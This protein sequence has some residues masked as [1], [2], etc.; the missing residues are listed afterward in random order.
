MAKRLL[1]TFLFLVFFQDAWAADI[2]RQKKE[3]GKQWAL[4]YVESPEIGKF[5]SLVATP[6]ADNIF[7]I[8]AYASRNV[9]ITL[10]NPKW[11][12]PDNKTVSLTAVFDNSSVRIAEFMRMRPF[13]ASVNA[14]MNHEFLFDVLSLIQSGNR[15]TLKFSSGEGM[16]INLLGA[17]EALKDWE[18]CARDWAGY[19]VNIAQRVA[20]QPLGA[21]KLATGTGIIVSTDGHIVTNAHVV[22]ECLKISVGYGDKTVDAVLLHSDAKKDLAL[23]QTPMNAP[24]VAQIAE[25]PIELGSKVAVFGFP[26]YGSLSSGGNFTLGSVSGLSGYRDDK[27]E[28]Q[29]TA[30]I[31]GG[32]SGGPVVDRK[33]RLVGVVKATMELANSGRIAQ[34]VNFAIRASVLREFLDARKFP[35]V[36]ASGAAGRDRSDTDLAS[37]AKAV[38]AL[39][40]CSR[41]D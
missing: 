16:S 14:A 6:S 29:I 23:L 22:R 8:A 20:P 34:N 26:L 3:Y 12:L 33:G 17:T 28:F 32:N 19:V 37:A 13:L 40:V 27:G 24:R 9:N 41:K 25:H 21:T 38:S 31:Q 18:A 15:M 4:T 11:K 7:S 30:P 10:T 1:A 2:V 5:C 39:V 35:Y 36:V